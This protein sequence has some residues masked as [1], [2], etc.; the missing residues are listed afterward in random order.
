MLI[1][2]AAACNPAQ[3]EPVAATAPSGLEV[4]ETKVTTQS[5]EMHVFKTEVA[6]TRQQQNRGLMFRDSMAPDEGMIFP[7]DPPQMLSFWMKN[8]YI[9]LDIIYVGEDGR[10]INIHENTVPLR[11]EPYVSFDD[12]VLVLEINGGRSAELGIAA[13][14]LVEWPR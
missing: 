9:P 8:T 14:D 13:G 6:R 1:S 4:V 2:P 5:G 11:E 7:Y 10:I 12:A 3:E